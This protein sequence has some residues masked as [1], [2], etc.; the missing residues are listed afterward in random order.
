L[1][2]TQ[3]IR[4]RVLRGI[5]LNR[6]PGFHFPGNFLDISFDRVGRDASHL[7]L[8][9]GPWC[10]DADGQIDLGSLAMLA[11]LAL[12]ACVRAQLRRETR[13][14]TVSMNLQFTGAPR[15]GRLKAT[16]L[17]QGFFSHATGRLG[18]SRV[19][20]EGRAG[21]VCYGSGTFM[22]LE[23]PHS[24]TLHP[25]P[26][27]TRKSPEPRRLTEG[28]LEKKEMEILRR[29]DAAL[30]A[31]GAFI[32]HFWGCR[33]HR[34]KSGAECTLENGLHIGNRVGHAQGGI[35]FALAAATAAAALPAHWRLSGISAWYTSPGDGPALHASARPVHHGRQTAVV[36]TRIGGRSRRRV[37][38]VVTTHCA[39]A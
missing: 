22:A 20:V 1:T 32:Q 23:P 5:A 15:T 4:E 19:S 24:V 28:D 10:A 16:G 25:V 12:A 6:Q 2:R 27:R 37:L 21:L 39:S 11:D 35:L 34:T 17:F 36:R 3:R 8:D 31:E 13:L 18:M 38:E 14:A 30:A 7:S 26:L 9:P 29:A 33:P